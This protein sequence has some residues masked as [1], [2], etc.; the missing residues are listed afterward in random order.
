MDGKETHTSHSQ[1]LR[2]DQRCCNDV[3]HQEGN[4]SRQELDVALQSAQGCKASPE[5][6]CTFYNAANSMEVRQP[7]QRSD[8]V[9]TYSSADAKQQY[10]LDQTVVWP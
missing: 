3:G 6:P 7:D 4:E 9:L 10:T 1:S 8:R 2:A 5:I